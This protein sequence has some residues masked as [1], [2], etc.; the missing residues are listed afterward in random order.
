MILQIGYYM[1]DCD[2]PIVLSFIE[3]DT[4]PWNTNIHSGEPRNQFHILWEISFPMM[5]FH[6]YEWFTGA[7]NISEAAYYEWIVSSK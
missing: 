1:Y 2:T 5:S 4:A 3:I 7:W 6:L